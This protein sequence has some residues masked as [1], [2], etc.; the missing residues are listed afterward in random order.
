[1]DK[2]KARNPD[3]EFE[4]LVDYRDKFGNYFICDATP[5]QIKVHRIAIDKTNK[6]LEELVSTEEF[7]VFNPYYHDT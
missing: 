5:N 4:H 6:K 7:L 3:E 1:M 2:S